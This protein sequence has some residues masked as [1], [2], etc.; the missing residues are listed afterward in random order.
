MGKAKKLKISGST[1]HAPLGDQINTDDLATPSTRPSKDRKRT[2]EEDVDKFVDGKL[3]EK[4]LSQARQQVKDLEAEELPPGGNKAWPKQSILNG[5]NKETS[6][7]EESEDDEKDTDVASA[8]DGGF[9]GQGFAKDI[10]INYRDQEAFDLFMNRDGAPRK[11]L[12]DIISE[13]IAEKRTEMDTQYSESSFGGTEAKAELDPDVVEMYEGVGRVLE[14]YRSGKIPKAFKVIAQFRN[15]EELLV[16]T[17]PDKWT[18]AAVYKATKIFTANLKEKMAQ[19]FFNQILLP[20]VLDDI[21][22]YQRL[23]FHLY[24]A[25]GKALFKPGAFFKGFLLP[26]CEG[27][28][29]TLRMAII[30]GSM[31]AKRSIPMLHSAAVMLKIAEM[32]Y[33]GACSIFLRILFDKKYAL[34]YRVVDSVVFHFLRFRNEKRELPVLWHQS[35]LTFVQRYKGH[36]SSEQKEAV[37][38]LLKFQVHGKIT[39]E[40]RRELVHAVCRDDEEKDPREME[41]S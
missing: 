39:P 1:R 31:L 33:S 21:I 7:D 41:Q 23:N 19:R 5:I 15:W 28:D 29:C 6:S 25:I 11:T 22:T 40:I 26:L 24:Q 17:R 13:K 20:R 27:G 3:S 38:E 37:M 14:R 10:R 35:L 9:D 34:P 18:A 2:D 4:I 12:A 8:A 36:I 30:I 32:E 16:L